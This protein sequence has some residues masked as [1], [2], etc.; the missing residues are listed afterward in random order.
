M[1]SL[2]LANGRELE[3]TRERGRPGESFRVAM[4]QT[5]GDYRR[6][7]GGFCCTRAELALLLAGWDRST[8]AA[9]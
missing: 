4:Y 3:L 2:P 6:Q 5:D 9:A 7:E 8:P 1:L